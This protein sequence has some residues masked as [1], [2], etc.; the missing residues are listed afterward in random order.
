MLTSAGGTCGVRWVG[1]C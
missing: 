1:V